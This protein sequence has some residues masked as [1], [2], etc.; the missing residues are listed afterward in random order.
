MSHPAGRLAARKR[1]ALRF[2]QHAAHFGERRAQP[3]GDLFRRQIL[4]AVEPDDLALAKLNDDFL[5]EITVA[6]EQ[7]RDR[8]DVFS[9]GGISAD[10]RARDELEAA[11]DPRNRRRIGLGASLRGPLCEAFLEAQEVERG[12]A[13]QLCCAVDVAFGGRERLPQ[14]RPLQDE[15]FRP[16]VDPAGW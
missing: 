9:F 16:Q 8:F 10:R 1:R 12:D 6:A 13:Q 3:Q 7:P 15:H 2:R 4:V 14:P 11:G 5:D